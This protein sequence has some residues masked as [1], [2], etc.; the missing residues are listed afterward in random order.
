MYIYTIVLNIKNTVKLYKQND[1]FELRKRAKIIKLS[2]I[3][4]WIFHFFISALIM[5]FF[6]AISRGM[7][8]IFV[9]IPMFFTYISLLITSIF[10]IAFI[11]LLNKNKYL[12]RYYIHILL[13]LC[14]VIDIIDIIYLLK[15]I[16]INLE[17]K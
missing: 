10:S 8:I 6:I 13:Q 5:I 14:F 4:F 1:V 16:D 3:P 17:E 15:K 12:K 2:L 11:L 7:G 9:P